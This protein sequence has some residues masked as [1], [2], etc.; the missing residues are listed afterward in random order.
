MKNVQ[1]MPRMIC[2]Q[3]DS[4][5]NMEFQG[6]SLQI[7]IQLP[8]YTEDSPKTVDSRSLDPLT[9]VQTERPT[10]VGDDRLVQWCI[11]Q[12]L[13]SMTTTP[14]CLC[15]S[16]YTRKYNQYCNLT[17]RCV[18]QTTPY[19]KKPMSKSRTRTII[20]RIGDIFCESLST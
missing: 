19:H 12:T 18:K 15:C 10:A 17:P 11:S 13:F 6:L 20:I 5:A 16:S 2:A 4:L 9:A 8:G 14:E 7:S 1:P 3:V